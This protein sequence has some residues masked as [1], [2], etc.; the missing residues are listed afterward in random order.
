MGENIVNLYLTRY[1]CPEYTILLEFNNSN[2]TERWTNDL[3]RN[4]S[5]KKIYYGQ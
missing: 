1:F 5:L 2:S 4:F 3:S